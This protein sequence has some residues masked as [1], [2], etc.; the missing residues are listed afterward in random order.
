MKAR[1]IVETRGL[2]IEISRL[3]GIGDEGQIEI[4]LPGGRGRETRGTSEGHHVNISISFKVEGGTR[5]LSVCIVGVEI[6]MRPYLM[7]QT[8]ERKITQTGERNEEEKRDEAEDESQRKRSDEPSCDCQVS[9]LMRGG[10]SRPSRRQRAR[11][12]WCCLRNRR[13]SGRVSNQ[14]RAIKT[15]QESRSACTASNV[16]CS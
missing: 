7:A 12:R 5:V 1:I 8:G 10:V 2:L 11:R 16:N 6:E 14:I 3:E 13:F 15:E 4:N 9:D